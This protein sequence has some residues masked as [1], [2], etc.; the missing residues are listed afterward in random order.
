MTFEPMLP[1]EKLDQLEAERA[2]NS[3]AVRCAKCLIHDLK[4]A[5][6]TQICSA[7]GYPFERS[8]QLALR[9][10]L[11]DKNRDELEREEYLEIRRKL[12]DILL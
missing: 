3:L 10:W 7:V 4:I 2:I 5:E 9:R 8:N 12:L 11:L 6:G 1:Q